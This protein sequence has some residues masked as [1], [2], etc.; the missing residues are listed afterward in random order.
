MKIS[1]FS[2][3]LLFAFSTIVAVFNACK[4]KNDD[5][6]PVANTTTPGGNTT[7]PGGNTTTTGSFSGTAATLVIVTGAQDIEIGKTLKYEARF[8]DSNGNTTVATGVTWTSASTDIG[9]FNGDI[10][11]AKEVGSTRITATAT[12]GGRTVTASVIVGVYQNKFFDVVPSAIVWT[13]GAGNIRL[14][15]VYFG[16]NGTANFTYTSSNPSVVTVDNTG[17]ITFLSAGEAVI[18]VKADGLQ[19]KPSVN[20][21]IL[22]IGSLVTEAPLPVVR[23]AIDPNTAILFKGQTLQFSAKAFNSAGAEVPNQTVTWSVVNDT[24]NIKPNAV[25]ISST[26]LVKANSVGEATVFADIRGIRAEAKV[27]VYPDTILVVTPYYFEK[28]P[29]ETQQLEAKLYRVNRTTKE[30]ESTPLAFTGTIKWAV[31]DFSDVPGEF[32]S[33]FDIATV[34]Q[35]GLV[36]V[37]QN[38]TANMATVIEAYIENTDIGGVSFLVVKSSTVVIP[39]PPTF[40]PGGGGGDGGFDF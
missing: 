33:M 25:E 16:Q 35:T 7:T 4:P 29:G 19:G 31:P 13:I 15:P 36:T 8:V 14:N 1:H 5:P 28:A 27:Q 11:T 39:P 30:V 20:V 38:A 3:L 10:F 2:L 18:T 12:S 40:P 17:D 37:K 26:G 21:P 22:V 34:S 24:S 6:A 9:T 32:A 23:V